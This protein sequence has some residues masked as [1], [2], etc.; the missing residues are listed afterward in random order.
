MLYV[1]IPTAAEIA[2]LCAHC[3]DFCVSIYLPTSPVTREAGGDRIA[4]KN[5]AKEA[6]RQLDEAGADKRRSAAIG[7]HLAELGEDDEFWRFQAHSLA[8]FATPDNVRSFRLPN[9]L[10]PVVEVADRFYVKPLLRAVSFA[11]ACYVLALS[12]QAV[13][14]IEVSPDLPTAEVKIDGLP[15]DAGRASRSDIGADRRPLDRQPRSVEAEKTFLRQYCRQIDK[16]L[17]PMLTGSDIPLVLAAAEPIA[18]IYRSVNSY[19]HLADQA[20]EG[21]PETLSD[22]ELGRRA[23]PV[24]DGVY[25][26]ELAHWRDRFELRANQGRATTDIAQ[27]ARAATM[28]AVDSML[29]DIDET[30]PGT[31]DED[32]AV[33]FAE[34]ADATNY[35]LV[36]E[37]AS[38]VIATGGRVIGVRRPDIPDGKP[39]AAILR[40]PV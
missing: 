10:Q 23:R 20:I 27:A 30:M 32:G 25:R 33:S 40:H 16:A 6:L 24:L 7:E 19:A 3:G 8:V 11:N 12:Q 1:D 35:G 21:N 17:R 26:H 31:I 15:S 2:A 4:F 9:A 14:V 39:L 18:S 13:R 28:G 5:Q 22:A 36:D 38:R 29:A 34:A 37:I